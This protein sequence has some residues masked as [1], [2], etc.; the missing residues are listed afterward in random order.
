MRIGEKHIVGRCTDPVGVVA[1]LALG[2]R[3][4]CGRAVFQAFQPR[5]LATC[6]AQ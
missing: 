4:S 3:S 5:R 2:D 1:L 6:A